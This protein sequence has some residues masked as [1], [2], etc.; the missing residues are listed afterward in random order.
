MVLKI[1][2]PHPSFINELRALEFY[3]GNGAVQLLAS[4]ASTYA[5]LLDR[6]NP[7][8]TARS[9]FPAQD[10]KAIEYTCRVMH[11]LHSKEIN[12]TFHF[13][14]MENWFT[15]FETLEI[16]Q[17]LLPHVRKADAFRF[18]FN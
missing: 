9:L 8:T 15:L 16:P 17:D 10:D 14:T 3:K 13:Q 11:Q 18:K 12:S 5:M 6:L 1:G 7:G 4:D 2:A